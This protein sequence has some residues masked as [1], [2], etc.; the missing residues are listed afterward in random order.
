[1]AVRRVFITSI[2][3]G[4]KPYT[5]SFTVDDA[6]VN[7]PALVAAYQPLVNGVV[8]SVSEALQLVHPNDRKNPLLVT[9]AKLAGLY[10]SCIAKG[11]YYSTPDPLDEPEHK[12]RA[13]LY[14]EGVNK[15]VALGADETV[16]D[17]VTDFLRDWA[18]IGPASLLPD[19]A[20]VRIVNQG[21]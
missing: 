5:S 21:I 4:G 12:L 7:I 1:M 13:L 16:E 10:D 14:L 6:T 18:R 17:K 20:V 2:A 15:N 11:Y 9:Q 8:I 3:A 19:N